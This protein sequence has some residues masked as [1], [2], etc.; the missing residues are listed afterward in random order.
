M[1]IALHSQKLKIYCLNKKKRYKKKYKNKFTKKK[2]KCER[3]KMNQQ[4][5]V[6]SSHTIIALTRSLQ[7][8][9]KNY[10]HEHLNKQIKLELKKK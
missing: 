3:K 4:I 6:A 9:M 2:M 1:C 8:Y 10:T 5:V 7:K